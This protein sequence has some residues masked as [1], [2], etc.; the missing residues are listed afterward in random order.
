MWRKAYPKSWGRLFE[1]YCDAYLPGRNEEICLRADK[2]YKR[3]LN[4]M[5]DLGGKE[6]GMAENMATWF[7]IVAFYEASDHVI[8][9]KAF[10][11]IHGWH[12]DS[13]RFL[14]K[15]LMPIKT[16]GH[17]SS[18]RRY[19]QSTKS[20]SGSIRQK[21]NGR[22]HG[23]LRSIP[24][25]GWKGTAST[26]SDVRSQSMQKSMVMRNCCHICVRPIIPWHMCSMQ[27]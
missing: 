4:Q 25:T 9:G 27:N 6:N 18:L 7:S 15:S 5:P 10:Q 11:I 17:I 12:I 1:K 14:G 13:L 24:I 20:R 23:E 16:G 26:W 21:E 3:L 22:I 19:I 2:E 8:D